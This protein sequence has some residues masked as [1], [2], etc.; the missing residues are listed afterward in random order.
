M[1]FLFYFILKLI[2]NVNAENDMNKLITFLLVTTFSVTGYCEKVK[3]NDLT[4]RNGIYFKKS[5]KDP[6]TQ[7]N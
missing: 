1:N 4:E 2:I 7:V 3:M 6:F 5:S